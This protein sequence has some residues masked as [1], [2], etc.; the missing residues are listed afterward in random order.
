MDGAFSNQP[1]TYYISPSGNDANAGT[2]PAAPWQTIGRVNQAVFNPGDTILFQGGATFSGNLIFDANDAGTSQSPI[3]VGSYGSGRAT[4]SA[5]SGDG[6]T[7]HDTAGFFL[8]NLNIQGAGPGV[9]TATGVDL[10]N[11]LPGVVH[12]SHVYM[13]SVDVS[14]FGFVG[15]GI[16]STTLTGGFTDVS[17][18][19]STVHNDCESGIFSYAGTFHDNPAPYG[20]AH[21][22]IYIAH[23]IAYGNAGKS[24]T[25]D[26]GNGIELGNVDGAVIERC[27]AHDNG[28]LNVSTGG[29]PIGIWAYNSNNVT[30]QYNESYNNTAAHKDGGG[31]DLDGGCTNCLVQYNYSHD[32]AGAGYLLTQFPQATLNSNNVFRYN[33]SQNDGR[34]NN[35]PAIEVS[36]SSGSNTVNNADI[37]GNTIYLSK[38]SGSTPAAIIIN[39]ATNN[40]HVRN[41][42]FCVTGG[43]QTVVVKAAGA[44]LLF[45]GNDYW[46]GSA[47]AINVSYTGTTY[48]TLAAWQSA[49]GQEKLGGTAVGAAVNPQLQNA[50]GGVTLGNADLLTSDTAYRLAAG[51]PLLGAGVNLTALGVNPGTMDYFGNP[52]LYGNP[53]PAGAGFNI[54]A[55]E[56]EAIPA[57][58]MVPLAGPAGTAYLRLSEDGNRLDLWQD[59]LSPGVGTPTQSVPLGEISAIQI[60]GGAGNDSVTLDLADPPFAVSFNGGGGNDTLNINAGVYTFATDPSAMNANLT[61]NDNAAVVFTAAAPGTGI[62]ARY[63]AALNLGDGATAIMEPAAD[64]D[65]AVLVVGSLNFAGSNG[66]WRGQL[67]LTDNDLI[68]RGGDLQAITSQLK[69]GSN[70]AGYGYWNGQ[71]IISST[72]GDDPMKLTSLG[73]MQQIATGTFDGQTVGGGDVLVKYTWYGDADLSGKVDGTDYTLIDHGYN[74]GAIGW[75]NGDFNYDGQVDG[76][77]YSLI[78]NAFNMQR[79]S[80]PDGIVVPRATMSEEPGPTKAAAAIV[81]ADGPGSLPVT[82]PIPREVEPGQLVSSL[83][84][85]SAVAGVIL[86]Q[87]PE[88]FDRV[89]EAVR[90]TP[91][92]VRLLPGDALTTKLGMDRNSWA[93]SLQADYGT[94]GSLVAELPG[95]GSCW[96]LLSRCYWWWSWRGW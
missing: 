22:N 18:T 61:V 71:G 88:F 3:I 24:G 21:S 68:V 13:D 58:L 87:G 31:F 91:W 50:G 67:D 42:I 57:P 10:L 46:T 81:S 28:A 55:D 72:A 7:I 90:V 33:L 26:S 20:L 93:G 62:N 38:P 12:L 85:R 49:K 59:A 35:Y 6:I 84:N 11:D 37:Y 51:S 53:L 45:Q 64:A 40:V 73:V 77:D 52:L 8:S 86:M 92:P 65:R 70:V 15:I 82:Q 89:M 96:L 4:L 78:D 74:A 2:S 19:N 9:N 43:L 94:G 80:L 44:G 41:N 34:K 14:G 27:V 54:G 60:I 75:Q 47:G 83:L 32:N 30:I 39:Q 25:N 48:N 17:I 1:Q 95:V 56:V 23:V 63:L 16:G 69:A 79:P 36:A 76:T 29:G 66:D 5:G